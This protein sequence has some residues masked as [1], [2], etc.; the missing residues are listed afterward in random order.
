MRDRCRPDP[1]RVGRTCW[2]QPAQ[3]QRHGAR[4]GAQAAQGDH[5]PARPGV[6]PVHPGTL[7]F[8][9]AA[10]RLGA[11][12]ASAVPTP[13]GMS[14]PPFVGRTRELALLERH[15]RGEGP[16]LL[17][18]AGEPGIGKTRLLQRGAAAGRGAGAGVCSTGA[19]SGSG[20]QEP[21]APLLDALRALHP[22]P[23]GR[24]NCAADLRGCAWLVRLL[25]ELAAGPIPPL[26]PWTL[27]PEQERR[28]MHEAVGR[29]L[30]NVAGPAGT[31]LVL[32][33]LQWAGADALDL[34]ATLVRAARARARLPLRVVG[35]YRD[36][37]VRPRDPL[38][39][40]WR[41]WRT[42]DWPPSA[43]GAAAPGGGR[44]AARCT[45]GRERRG[46]P[47]AAGAG[48]AAR[49]RRALLP[50]E[51]RC[52]RCSGRT[53]RAGEEDACPGTWR[54]GCASGWR[55]CPRWRRR[56]WAWRRCWAARCT[57]PS[58][59]PSWRSR[60]RRC[61]RRWMRRARRACWSRRRDDATGSPTT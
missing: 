20:G 16:P 43:A 2:H 57:A 18:L 51:L 44:A 22:Q 36:T 9:E 31:L 3:P 29:F 27:T 40:C 19:A 15:L 7:P 4:G 30:A 35:A 32:D 1:G 52:R 28:L 11:N 13:T 25:P 12:A 8:T 55:R 48:A 61:W 37:E 46:R 45:A 23:A 5:R 59:R 21:Y 26:P 14:G 56:C 58:S 42:P 53:A 38:A 54:R 50:G 34:L 49:G 24:A 41:T 10:R 6:G 33:D 47:G 60:S 17:L 39:C